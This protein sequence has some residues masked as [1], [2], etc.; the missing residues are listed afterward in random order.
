[1]EGRNAG[2]ADELPRNLLDCLTWKQNKTMKRLLLIAAMLV[3]LAATAQNYQNPSFLTVPAVYVTNT[4]A[5]TNLVLNTGSTNQANTVYSN[6]VGT[7]LTRIIAGT[8]QTNVQL[9]RDV[10]LWA[11][12]EGRWYPLGTTNN[13][14]GVDGTSSPMMVSVTGVGGSGANTAMTLT[15]APVYNTRVRSDGLIG[16]HSTVA[17]EQWAPTFTPT[18]T[19]AFTQGIAVP[20]YKWPGARALRLLRIVGGDTDASSQ[21]IISDISLTGYRP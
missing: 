10:P 16:D 9:L 2:Y 8:N 18:T 17:A 13:T 11:D 14:I 4:L 3:S 6:Y 7:T 1:M 15:F 21:V 12:R 20:A 19:T 5:I